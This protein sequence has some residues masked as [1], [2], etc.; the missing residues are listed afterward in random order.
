MRVTR[1]SALPSRCMMLW[2]CALFVAA[3]LVAPAAASRAEDK[4]PIGILRSASSWSLLIGDEMG[5]FK[6]ENIS[7]DFTVFNSGAQM[8]P[9]L[10]TGEL[11]LG[12]GAASAALYNAVERGI[13]LK[14][15]ADA[16]RNAPGYGTTVLVRRDLYDSGAIKGLK[17]LKGRRVALSG[18][19]SSEESSLDQAMRSVGL[20]YDDVQKVFMGF[21]DHL[22]AFGNH[23]IDA[24]L[25][26]EPNATAA[27]DAGVASFLMEVSEYY[28]NMETSVLM[29]NGDFARHHGDVL[30]RFMLGYLRG[31]RLYNDA[32]ANGHIAGPG[33][34]A[35]IAILAKRSNV[36]DPRILRE[37]HAVAVNPDGAVNT[38]AMK[39]D[40]AFFL[41]QHEIT[42]KV[43]VDQV[44]DM[45]FVDAAL[46]QL[47]P[48]RAKT[49]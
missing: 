28:P 45:S 8:V 5:Y 39:T 14:V 2:R 11:E 47:G 36:H 34:D 41:R 35:I 24:S 33:A 20:Q 1:H 7:L 29:T 48:Y 9:P 32:L 37:M 16:L 10:A 25:T 42:G 23:A 46:A 4:L 49:P 43:T 44:V 27:V 26:G 13:D 22:A 19:G 15:I 3:L 12:V 6:A 38:A 18:Q 21:P 31:V 30:G 17:D 40:W